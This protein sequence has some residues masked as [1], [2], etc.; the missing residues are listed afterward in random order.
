MRPGNV[1]VSVN[2]VIIGSGI[3]LAPVLC[4]AIITWTNVDFFVNQNHKDKLQWY[5]NQNRKIFIPPKNV[6]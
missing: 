5:L 1:Y 3:G 6:F 4:Q 2:W